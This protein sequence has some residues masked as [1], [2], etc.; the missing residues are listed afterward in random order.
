VQ[1]AGI[2]K[3]LCRYFDGLSPGSLIFLGFERV[4]YVLQFG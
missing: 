2:E 1:N 4:L 3:K